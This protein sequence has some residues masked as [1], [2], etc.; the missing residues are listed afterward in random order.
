MIAANYLSLEAMRNGGRQIA[1]NYQE[2]DGWALSLMPADGFFG[3]VP[4]GLPVLISDTRYPTINDVEDSISSSRTI[5]INFDP[6]KLL[7]Q[8][9]YLFSNR[10]EMTDDTV[11]E[12]LDTLAH[13]VRPS[14]VFGI[15]KSSSA[16][17]R[18]TWEVLLRIGMRH[19]HKARNG[20]R[21]LVNVAVRCQPRWVD[22]TH[23]L[24][25]AALSS[26]DI[27]LVQ[28]L[29]DKGQNPAYCSLEGM[30][31]EQTGYSVAAASGATDCAQLLIKYCHPN[32]VIAAPSR[33][34]SSVSI[35]SAFLQDLLYKMASDDVHVSRNLSAYLETLGS[36]LDVDVN[37][38]TANMIQSHELHNELINSAKSWRAYAVEWRISCLDFSFYWVQS[39][40]DI[41]LPYSH[42]SRVELTRSG[43]CMAA[44]HGQDRLAGYLELHSPPPAMTAERCL[45]I[46]LADQFSPGRYIYFK[47]LATQRIRT[48]RVLVEYGVR[49]RE[50]DEDHNKFLRNVVMTA[51]RAG[52][53]EDLTFLLDHLLSA[54]ARISGGAL[55]QSIE[56][57]G[58]DVLELL[59]QRGAD[60]ASNG[61]RALLEAAIINNYDAV[62]LLLKMGVDI[63][64]EFTPP[65]SWFP[66]T[67]LA[68]LMTDTIPRRGSD[69]QTSI[70][71]WRFFVDNG[72]KLRLG[73][74]DTNCYELLVSIF[75][76]GG[77]STWEAFN[78]LLQFEG[79]LDELSPLQWSE[80]IIDSLSPRR[81]WPDW[82]IVEALIQR[83]KRYGP[84]LQPNLSMLILHN[85]PAQIVMD[86]IA[87]GQS[88]NGYWK[89]YTPLQA[90][91]LRLNYEMASHLLRLGADINRLNTTL[92]GTPL[93][94]ACLCSP[95]AEEMGRQKHMVK[96]LVAH[97]ADVNAPAHGR[98]GRT[99]LQSICLYSTRT[100]DAADHSR[101]L[102]LFLLERGANGNAV[103]GLMGETA[104]H[105]C[106]GRGDLDMATILVQHGVDL[107]GVPT[108]HI[109]LSMPC[110]YSWFSVLDT[111]A[112]Y[113]RLDMTQYLLNA[114]ALS[115]TPGT[116]GFQGAID[117]AVYRV[118]HA[119]AE[120]IR[121]HVEK[122]TILR[123]E[124]PDMALAH[125]RCVERHT[126]AVQ[127]RKAEY[128]QERR[129]K[130]RRVR[131][132]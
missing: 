62:S 1:I 123:G 78:F 101:W 92:G 49:I 28:H 44:L 40:F 61:Q 97:G 114:G 109:D 96:L 86:L 12:L 82:R 35:F 60:V 110:L 36:M 37:V 84:T 47:P 63:N 41:L 90:A 71:M 38:D 105:L 52:I 53:Q 108:R 65:Q 67:A 16:S 17:I 20:L 132:S 94:L 59:I 33:T 113:G 106:V 88:I 118:H 98:D 103:P 80:L 6:F 75:T 39:I 116:S 95:C 130:Q 14:I 21:L 58:T 85:C 64:S 51:V 23:D 102:I 117:H 11:L 50:Q 5:A 26:G 99:A 91:A 13:R 4:S 32:N 48:A 9:V 124:N 73:S 42:R 22:E 115:A 119:V 25:F 122:V 121:E 57:T 104:L 107:N 93:Q 77:N 31:F 125:Q 45:E 89:G 19:R 129:N 27:G 87:A 29:L 46:T 55:A 79:E 112:Y 131:E 68:R 43:I 34:M 127:A 120:V 3:H 56:G 8:A 111:A 15:F 83:C 100:Q 74:T 24:I 54:G 2:I 18:A 70:K 10:L 69:C 126:L 81:V 76:I 72:A 66:S 7:A 30:P 128:Q